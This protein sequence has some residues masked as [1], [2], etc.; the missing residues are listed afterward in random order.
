MGRKRSV[1]LFALPSSLSRAR[2]PCKLAQA[3]A[4]LT[5]E[6]Q[7]ELLEA[8][9]K[10]TFT[11]G[12]GPLDSRL[13]ALGLAVKGETGKAPATTS[14]R[15]QRTSSQPIPAEKPKNGFSDS[16]PDNSPPMPSSQS[17]DASGDLLTA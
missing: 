4:D 3:A 7:S 14:P 2:E 15:L 8:I 9:G 5:I 1:V 16:L 6:E 11:R 17:E 10:A 13:R 12:F